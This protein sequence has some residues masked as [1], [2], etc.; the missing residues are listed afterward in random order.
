MTPPFLKELVP[1][2]IEYGTSLLVEFEPDSLWYETSL[3]IAAQA[4]KAGIR[5]DYHTFQHSPDG[6]KKAFRRWGLDVMKMEQDETLWIEDSYT[7]QTGMGAPEEQSDSSKVSVKLSDWSIGFAKSMKGGVPDAWKRRLHIDDN[8][9]ILLQYNEEKALIDFWRTRLI[10]YARIRESV[11]MYAILT[12]SASISF[13]KQLESLSDGIID[14]K[15]EERENEFRHYVRIRGLRGRPCDTHWR[16]LRLLD[17]GEV[18]IADE[19]N[20]G[21]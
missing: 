4:V 14:F 2:G 20:Q 19:R 16:E 10:P 3:T 1:G 8:I 9:G 17:N 5:T 18:A 11:G 13:Y 7:I 12:N 21:V 15:S 6:V